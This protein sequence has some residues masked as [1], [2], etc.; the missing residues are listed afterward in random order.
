[1]SNLAV[2]VQIADN[3]RWWDKKRQRFPQSFS[4]SKRCR[5]LCIVRNPITYCTSETRL[6]AS[7]FGCDL[8]NWIR[9][10]KSLFTPESFCFIVENVQNDRLILLNLQ[11][12][13]HYETL[14]FQMIIQSGCKNRQLSSCSKS[15]VGKARHENGLT[16]EHSR[17]LSSSHPKSWFDVYWKFSSANWCATYRSLY[18]HW[19]R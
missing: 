17:G 18:V 4:G 2:T 13:I 15:L 5:M 12:R 10:A 1:M 7:T 16:T 3:F 9:G 19:S 8:G 14:A 11:T 6:V